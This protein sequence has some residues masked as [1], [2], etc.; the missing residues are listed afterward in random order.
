MNKWGKYWSVFHI[1]SVVEAHLLS[2]KKETQAITNSLWNRNVCCFYELEKLIF[3]QKLNRSNSSVWRNCYFGESHVGRINAEWESISQTSGKEPYGSH[4]LGNVIYRGAFFVFRSIIGFRG[5]NPCVSKAGLK[6][7]ITSHFSA[8]LHSASKTENQTSWVSVLILGC[9]IVT[10]G[11]E[12]GEYILNDQLELFYLHFFCSAEAVRGKNQNNDITAW[13]TSWIF[14][15]L[16]SFLFIL[17]KAMLCAALLEWETCV[18]GGHEKMH[19]TCGNQNC[20]GSFLLAGWPGC[21]LHRW[22]C[23][24]LWAG[25][26][27]SVCGCGVTFIPWALRFLQ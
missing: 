2:K 23:K 13:V 10:S 1:L 25:R 26:S 20:C 4:R 9:C 15:F 6:K 19:L 3:L 22:V 7:T 24:K 8:S 18:Q 11:G 12:A 17:W 5:T 16:A 27:G 21:V 14:L